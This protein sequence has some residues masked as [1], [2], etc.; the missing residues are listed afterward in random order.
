MI[1]TRNVRSTSFGYDEYFGDYYLDYKAEIAFDNEAGEMTK[2]KIEKRG[3]KNLER[4]L[5]AALDKYNPDFRIVLGRARGSFTF[6]FV[7]K[8]NMEVSRAKL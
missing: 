7:Q 6:K 4:A 8:P 5:N 3:C 1:T 2:I